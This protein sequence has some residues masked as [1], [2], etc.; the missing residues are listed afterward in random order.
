MTICVANWPSPPCA[1]RKSY[2]YYTFELITADP[3]DNKF[4]DC[5]VAAHADYLVSN[6]RHFEGL[7]AAGFPAVRV[8]SAGEFLQLL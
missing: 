8:V 2:T 5:Y 6:D 1:L 7:S 3:D 4:V